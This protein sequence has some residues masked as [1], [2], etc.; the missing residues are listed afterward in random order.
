MQQGL[1]EWCGHTAVHVHA[2]DS[3]A[4]DRVRMQLLLARWCAMLPHGAPECECSYV[5]RAE[6]V[7]RQFL[8]C[9]RVDVSRGCAATVATQGGCHAKPM[10]VCRCIRVRCAVGCGMQP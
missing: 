2:V 5:F 10:S 7:G 1:P 4:L 9:V 3:S 8:Y 6:F